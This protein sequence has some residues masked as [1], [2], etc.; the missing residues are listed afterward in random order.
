MDKAKIK[1]F[2]W[3][4]FI[5]T[6]HFSKGQDQGKPFLILF[7]FKVIFKDG[8]IKSGPKI[9]PICDL[10]GLFYFQLPLLNLDKLPLPFRIQIKSW[11]L[12]R[13]LFPKD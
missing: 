9:D 10:D 8:V 6:L 3:A 12:P 7:F 4:F 5:L 11:S 1:A 2:Q 13:I